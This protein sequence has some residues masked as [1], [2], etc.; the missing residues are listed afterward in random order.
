MLITRSFFQRIP[1]LRITSLFLIGI[2]I[3]HY[4]Q[5]EF[6]W[7]GFILTILL[8]ILIFLWHNSNFSAVKIQNILIS[9]C[10]ILSGVFY[11]Q[12]VVE[13]QLPTFD[14][15]NY[16][17]AEVCQKPAEKAK[18]WQ[19]I[20]WIKSRLISQPEKVIAY[21]SKENF[22]STLAVGDQLILLT[23]PQL[24]KNMGNPYEF[25][26]RTMMHNKNMYFSVYLSPG[27][28][29]KTGLKINRIIYLAE[30]VRDKLMAL[31]VA[32]KIEKDERAVL[33]ALTLG[34]RAELDPE[35]LGYFVDSGTIHVLS[36]SGLHIALIFYIISLLLTG[37]NK[38]KFGTVI[39]PAI[40][41]I[42]LWIYAFIAGFCPAIQRSTVMFTFVIIGNV[43][44][45]PINIYNSLSASAL[46]LILL[47]PNVLLDV[48]FQLSYL[49]VFGIVLLQPPLSN[50]I[51]VKNKILGWLW[52]MFTVSV[53]AQF[54]TF[55]LSVLYFNQFPNF[56]WLSNYFI[57]PATTLIIWLTFG[58]FILNPVP[59]IPDLLAQ[60]LQIIT[61]LMLGLLKWISELPNAVI[62]GIVFS[63]LQAFIIYGFL[64]AFII[65]V[66]SKKKE[67]LFF[68]LILCIFFQVSVLWINTDLF[69]QKT[70]YVYNSKNTLIHF[71]DGRVNYILSEGSNPVSEQEL[72]MIQNVQKH[73]KL[74]N[75]Q[76]INLKTMKDFEAID[77]KIKDES[78]RFLNSSLVFVNKSGKSN[79]N[80]DIIEVK[81]HT[82][83]SRSGEFSKTFIAMGSA[84]FSRKNSIPIDFR[85]KLNGACFLN[86]KQ[87]KPAFRAMNE[88]P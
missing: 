45:R 8:S 51:Q 75:P 26:Y 49:A 55:P 30:R 60:L 7:I 76:L 46:V 5:I 53:A 62:E 20:L 17:L 82:P 35:T 56:F 59:L 36:V 23:K 72:K 78:I 86:L 14:Q 34:Y 39:Y 74:K 1:F 84:Y 29:T 31:L 87:I 21:F 3:N 10:I 52:T 6:H 68:G 66:F 83:G 63:P 2:L 57:I 42:F 22:D 65:Y 69:N 79:Y 27:T 15:K 28:Y 43:L 32:T 33:S 67:W 38:G 11:P 70:V 71:I 73:L 41:I 80:N 9:L 48:G 88:T 19:S 54:I 40:M 37:I 13:N 64:A 12:K 77:L 18:T 24:I 50:L 25:D 44:R 4:L 58:F 85:T 61:H 81:I 16:F 47:D